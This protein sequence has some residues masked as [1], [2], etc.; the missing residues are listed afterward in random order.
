MRRPDT[1]EATF[2]VQVQRRDAK[3]R[4]GKYITA[5]ATKLTTEAPKQVMPGAVAIQLKVRIPDAAFD[6]ISPSVVVDIPADM[7][8]H[9][10][11]VIAE[12]AT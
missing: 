7:I 1:H 11:E 2:Y 12:D 9:A 10:I 8:Q 6:P 5:V 4:D 3:W